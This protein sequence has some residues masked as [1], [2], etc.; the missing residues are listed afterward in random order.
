[1][2]VKS[3]IKKY[4][5]EKGMNSSSDL[6]ERL[7]VEVEQLVEKAVKRADLNGRKT[8]QARDL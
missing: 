1:M 4:I 6:L 8:V 2:L 5:S 3:E 7:K